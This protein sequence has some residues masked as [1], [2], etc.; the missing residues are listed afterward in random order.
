MCVV[1]LIKKKNKG[2]LL[3][4]QATLN[5]KMGDILLTPFRAALGSFFCGTIY[6]LVASAFTYIVVPWQFQNAEVQKKN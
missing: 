3:P 2:A 6:L 1:L 4:V 5:K